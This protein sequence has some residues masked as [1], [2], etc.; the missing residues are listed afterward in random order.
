MSEAWWASSFLSN[1]IP[2]GGDLKI[3]PIIDLQ[4][5]RAFPEIASGDSL[6]D[7][8]TNVCDARIIPF[9]AIYPHPMKPVLTD[10]R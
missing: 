8:K 2:D 9:A 10:D 6:S 4:V 3:I 7:P 5:E 1:N